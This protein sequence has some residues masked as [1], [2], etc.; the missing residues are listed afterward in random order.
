MYTIIGGEERYIGQ[1]ESFIEY[2]G[3]SAN[4]MTA[5]EIFYGARANKL[6]DKILQIEVDK[7]AISLADGNAIE[8]SPID[9]PDVEKF[10]GNSAEKAKKLEEFYADQA[11][12][13]VDKITRG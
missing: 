9:H 2:K 10:S 4:G 7:A 3:G 1:V 5:S 6:F 8:L 11:S 13:L 12:R